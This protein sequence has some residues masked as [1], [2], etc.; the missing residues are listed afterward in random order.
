M[1]PGDELWFH[2]ELR[3]EAIPDVELPVL[4]LDDHLL[5]ID[6]PHDMATMPRGAHVLAS[7]LVRLRRETGIEYE[8]R[9]LGTTQLFRTQAQL[10]G[11]A[12]DI[13]V[14]REYGVPHELL[15]RDG[16]VRVGP[17]QSE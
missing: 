8:Q 5:V 2:R 12:R 17:S 15:D 4:H 14:L 10:D 7:A 6:K 3:P 9:K 11:A 16:I 13:A 1:R